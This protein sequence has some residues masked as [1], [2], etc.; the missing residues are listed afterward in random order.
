MRPS[1][2]TT[3]PV[4]RSSPA[5]RARAISGRDGVET[6]RVGETRLPKVCVEV[7]PELAEVDVGQAC[8]C[9]FPEDSP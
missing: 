4:S 5:A 9:H 8:A 6:V 7:D 2:T 3:M 1:I